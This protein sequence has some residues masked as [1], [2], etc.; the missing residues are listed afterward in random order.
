MRV[1]LDGHNLGLKQGTGIASYGRNLVNDLR[2]GGIDV[3]ILFGV[4]ATKVVSGSRLPQF[5]QELM[6]RGEPHRSGLKSWVPYAALY[7]FL[8]NLHYSIDAQKIDQNS[9]VYSTKYQEKVLGVD[10]IFNLPSVFRSAQAIAQISKRNFEITL[11][12]KVDIFHLTAPLPIS[13]SGAK[14]VVTVHDVIPLSVPDSTDV[15]LNYYRRCIQNS[16]GDADLICAVSERSKNDFLNWFPVDQKKVHVTYQSVSRPNDPVLDDEEQLSDFLEKRFDLQM[17]KYFLFYGAIEPKKNVEA[18]IHAALLTKTDFPL[19]VVGKNG[20]LYEDV[21][22]LLEHVNKNPNTRKKVIRIP[23]LPKNDL[24]RFIA[25]ARAV[26]VP[27]LYE[28]FG[29]AVA[30]SMCIGTPVI[31]SPAGSLS[32][33]AGGA[34]IIIDPN[35]PSMISAAMDKIAHDDALMRECIEKGFERALAFSP[36]QHLKR[37]TAAYS[38]IL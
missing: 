13:V 15:N 11:P 25:G 1:L 22:A 26:V 27:S 17:R 33:I 12:E 37:L 29:L 24:N 6:L 4:N 16:V 35:D 34:A 14:K 8:H 38:T 36:E 28:G 3:S 31:T 19:V 30:E 21:S 9:D 18:L 20:W 10:S 32:E 23:Y 2:L 5:V 7:S